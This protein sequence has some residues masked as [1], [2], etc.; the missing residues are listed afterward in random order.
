MDNSSNKFNMEFGISNFNNN[1]V[2]WDYISWF[3]LVIISH[4]K[5]KNAEI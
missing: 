4:N 2:L 1:C 3:L 5:R